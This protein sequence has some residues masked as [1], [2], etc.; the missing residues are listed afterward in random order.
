VRDTLELTRDLGDEGSKGG[1]LD[2]MPS[3]GETG[4]T[5]LPSHSQIL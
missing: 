3:N 4:G 5:G 2:E 1:T